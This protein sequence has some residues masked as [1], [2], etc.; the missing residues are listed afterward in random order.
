MI[1]Y[2]THS[3]SPLL[4]ILS[5]TFISSLALWQYHF[6]VGSAE[7]ALFRKPHRPVIGLTADN[8]LNLECGYLGFTC[9]AW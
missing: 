8:S 9:V 6:S 4:T 7:M 5:Q 2:M 3:A 1:C